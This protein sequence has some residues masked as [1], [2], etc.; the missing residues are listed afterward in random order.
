MN[1]QKYTSTCSEDLVPA[2]ASWACRQKRIPGDASGIRAGSGMRR[3]RGLIAV[4]VVDAAV[5]IIK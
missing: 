4:A 5:R 1:V 3:S 2:K